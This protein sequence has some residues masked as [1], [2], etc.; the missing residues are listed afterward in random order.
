MSFPDF[1]NNK[2][3]K[4]KKGKAFDPQA[5]IEKC[6]KVLEQIKVINE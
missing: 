1:L 5:V 2:K 4:D 3:K 6:H